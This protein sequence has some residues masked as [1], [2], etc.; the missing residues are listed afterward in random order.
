MLYLMNVGDRALRLPV[1]VELGWE[2]T[3]RNLSSIVLFSP[4][5]KSH[6]YSSQH[7]GPLGE[8][9]PHTTTGRPGQLM[10][11]IIYGICF[12]TRENKLTTSKKKRVQMR[13]LLLQKTGSGQRAYGRPGH[14]AGRVFL[15]PQPFKHQPA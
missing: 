1:P 10:N 6:P 3:Q 2:R 15:L 8:P 7:P 5:F 13:D 9:T 14:G 11:K 12:K 4:S